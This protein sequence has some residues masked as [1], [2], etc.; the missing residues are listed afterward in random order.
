[1]CMQCMLNA[2]AASAGATG[3][4]SWLGNKR[5]TWLT[6]SRLRLATILLMCAA[7]FASATL[8]SGGSTGG[9][10]ASGHTAAA[11]SR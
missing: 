9:T 10:R 6:P 8:V 1:M 5:F 11:Q 4:R 2:M 7:L 3:V